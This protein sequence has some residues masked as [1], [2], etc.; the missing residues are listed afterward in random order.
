M[1]RPAPNLK[2][3]HEADSKKLIQRHNSSPRIMRRRGDRFR[4]R[5]LGHTSRLGLGR[6]GR[7]FQFGRTSAPTTPQP[8]QAIRGPKL[9]TGTSSGHASV[10]STA[11]PRN[12]MKSRR[13]MSNPPDRAQPTT[14]SI[15]GC[16]VRH[17]AKF[18]RRC[19][20]GVIFRRQD[21]TAGTVGQ[22]PR[23]DILQGAGGFTPI[24]GAPSAPRDLD[25]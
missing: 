17:R 16:A 13:L 24:Q 5:R 22:P 11:P 21:A 20:Q 14:S 1:N 2:F 6:S 3:Q 23:A 7:S 4:L 25:S 19:L 9:C 12:V 10:G 15:R 18:G 8:V